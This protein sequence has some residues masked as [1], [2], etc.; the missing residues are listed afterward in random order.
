[1]HDISEGSSVGK[2]ILHDFGYFGHFLH[3]H[4]GGRA[5]K[6]YVLIRLLKSGG[7]LTQRELQEV[8]GT[9]SASMSEVLAKLESEGLIERVPLET[10]A[11]QRMVRLTSAGAAKATD[12]EAHRLRFEKDALSPLSEEEQGELAGMLDRVAAHWRQIEDK[13]RVAVHE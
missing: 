13:E 9:A 1:M 3:M 10:D 5:G 8:G 7:S 6:Q 11:R 4:V 12:I 2:R